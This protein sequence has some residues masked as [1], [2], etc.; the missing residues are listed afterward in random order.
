MHSF[1]LI[2]EIFRHIRRASQLHANR[3]RS[4]EGAAV[5]SLA[6]AIVRKLVAVPTSKDRTAVNDG[7]SGRAASGGAEEPDSFP[8]V[9]ARRAVQKDW[10]LFILPILTVS[11]M[12]IAK[13]DAVEL[14]AYANRSN[15]VPVPY[16]IS[17]R[18]VWEH[19]L[20][21]SGKGRWG[22]CKCWSTH[23]YLAR[24]TLR[25]QGSDLLFQFADSLRY[26]FCCGIVLPNLFQEFALQMSMSH[27]E[28]SSVRENG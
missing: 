13:D 17:A 3:L 11:L 15:H 12:P 21:L 27:Q 9:V 22:R 4:T 14:G 24:H 28:F 1:G 18:F 23:T 16:S 6:L 20:A 5:R 7:Y 26:V 10:I 2:W 8:S 25:R 19:S